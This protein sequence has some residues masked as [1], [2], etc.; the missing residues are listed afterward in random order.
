MKLR[1]TRRGMMDGDLNAGKEDDVEN[2]DAE[3][4]DDTE[5]A[6]SGEEPIPRLGPTVCPQSKCSSACQKS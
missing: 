2:D 4:E 5:D 1:M 6:D 3:E